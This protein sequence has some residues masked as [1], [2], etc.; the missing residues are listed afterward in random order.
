MVLLLLSVVAVL[1]YSGPFTDRSE[2]IRIPNPSTEAI[3]DLYQRNLSSLSCSCAKV[4]IRH[5]KFLS[6]RPSFHSI[7]AREFVSPAYRWHLFQNNSSN[8][9][10]ALITH[11]RTLAALCDRSEQ[12]I[13]NSIDDFDTRELIT[14]EPLTRAAF[15]IQ[16]Q[17][18]I[19]N[20]IRQVKSDYRR[21]LS[22]V[23]NSFGVNQLLHLYAK[24]WKI[25]FTDEN[26]KHVLKAF[27][28]RFASSNCTCAI[29]SN[30]SEPLMDGIR[31]GC[32]PYDGFRLSTFEDVSLGMLN[33]QL[34]V[35][36]WINRTDYTDYFRECQPRQCQYLLADKNNPVFMFTTVLGLYGGETKSFA[37]EQT[38]L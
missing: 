24:N 17:S 21:T 26:D 23:M 33:K 28:V 2:S 34:F 16:T 27:P 11:Y 9:S 10:A 12:Y 3:A 35:Q 32:F 25:D 4:T 19:D 30:C 14:I 38:Y 22:L 20:L 31:I 18:L 37:F 8:S 15:D 13:R 1:L 29:S 5:S 36:N 6:V 7:C